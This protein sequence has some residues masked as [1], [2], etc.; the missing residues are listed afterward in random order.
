VSLSNARLT[1][2]ETRKLDNISHFSLLARLVRLAR[3]A[4]I[5]SRGVSLNFYKIL[6]R[7][8][9]KQDSL[10]TRHLLV[11]LDLNRLVPDP[12]IFL[13]AIYDDDRASH[14]E[15]KVIILLFF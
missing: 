7:K 11:S 8:I 10:S 6:A 14:A 12:V 13:D 2:S 1:N 3:L 4:L 5:F 15:Q 9:A